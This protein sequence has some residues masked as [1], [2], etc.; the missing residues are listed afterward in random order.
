MA[1]LISALAVIPLHAEDTQRLFI[2]ANNAYDSGNYEVA[3]EGY[4]SL[5]AGGNESWELYY[6][7]GNA[8]YRLDEIGLAILNYERALRLAPTR[9][10][11]KDNLAL[12]SSKT[13][14]KIEEL[15]RLFLVDWFHAIV[16]LSTPR[17]WRVVVLVLVVLLSA[18]LCIFFV[19]SDYHLR[20]SMFIISFV[21]AFFLIISIINATFSA[22]NVTNSK[23]AIITAPMVVVK[24]SPDSKSL[25]KFVI[26]EGTKA[27]VTDQQDEWWQITLA[28]G[29]SGWINAGA[30]K[31]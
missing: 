9:R 5:I 4:T 14:D 8:Y 15:P 26:H 6:N 3:A 31:I 13:V 22:R 10:E 19:A 7:L 28:D 20:K 16:N 21:A 24:G 2:E 12:A 18:L 1:L 25:D 30:E 23:E 17:G 29:K 27:T 11:I